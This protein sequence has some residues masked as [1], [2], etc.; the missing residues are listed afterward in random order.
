MTAVP[1]RPHVRTAAM[2]GAMLVATALAGCGGEEAPRGFDRFEGDGFSVA[3]PREWRVQERAD[4][5]E[6][7]L[8]R[9][10]SPRDAEGLRAIMVVLR[11][12]RSFPTIGAVAT[13]VRITSPRELRKGR[14]V[15]ERNATVEGAEGAAIV[16]ADFSYAAP[17]K[18][19]PA[20]AL[21]LLAVDPEYEY[22]VVLAAPRKVLDK[23]DIKTTLRSFRLE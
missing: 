10:T 13:D 6:G 2:A 14:T 9:V 17:G 19:R 7:L 18:E 22:R 4:H 11:Q 3:Y 21:Q 20:R 12:K 8:L 23:L 16:I 5:D 1:D 15:G